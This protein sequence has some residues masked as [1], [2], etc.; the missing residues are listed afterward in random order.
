MILTGPTFTFIKLTLLFFYRRLF[1]VNQAWLRIA[2]WVNTVYVIL[3]LFGS[4]GYYLFQCWPPQWYFMR[5]YERYKRPPP[6]LI[7]GQCNATSVTNVSIPLIFGLFSDVMILLL[8][9]TTISGL[10]M[11]RR[12]KIGLTLVFSVG[13]MY[14]SC[15][16][17]RRSPCD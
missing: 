13:L 17:A 15:D 7:S 3:W 10:H 2:W 16:S 6:Y 9:I 14:V 8:P 11:T 5:Y 4:T 1:L 12:A